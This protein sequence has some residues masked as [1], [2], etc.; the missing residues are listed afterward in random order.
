M[1][2]IISFEFSLCEEKVL[3]AGAVPSVLGRVPQLGRRGPYGEG[4]LEV[5]SQRTPWSNEGD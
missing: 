5:E 2:G 3:G 1:E 4:L